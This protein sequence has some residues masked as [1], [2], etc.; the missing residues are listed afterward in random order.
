M[1]GDKLLFEARPSWKYFLGHILFSWLII[2][3]IIALWKR[4]A[5]VLRIYSD[6]VVLEKGVLSKSLT[7][8]YI[9]DLRV[10]DIKQSLVQRIFKIGEVRIGTAA[11][12]S[13][14]CVAYGMPNPKA[15]KELIL[16]QRKKAQEERER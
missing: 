7:E 8:L 14:E 13:Y 15:I 3:L 9:S 12:S 11:T 16:N 6:T 10:I 5:L 4:A 1:E 2:P